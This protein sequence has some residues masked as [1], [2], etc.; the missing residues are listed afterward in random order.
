M[1]NGTLLSFMKYLI[2]NICY[3]NVNTKVNVYVK[4]AVRSDVNAE[5]L[6]E[7]TR[8]ELTFICKL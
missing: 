2:V 5:A 3:Q 8:P 4:D 1:A 7:A 6:L